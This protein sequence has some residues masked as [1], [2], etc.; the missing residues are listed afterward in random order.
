VPNWY[1][2]KTIIKLLIAIALI[3]AAA[4][5]G[6]VVAKYYQLKDETLQLLTFG[7]NTT[8]NELQNRIIEKAQT[9][10]VPVDPADIIVTRDGFH[11][12]ATVSYAQSVEVVPSYTYPIK[13]HFTSEAISMSGLGPNN[14]GA[15]V[16]K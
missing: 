14:S 8:P 13:F 5:V 15:A 4:R 9:L 12:Y 1:V 10:S 11:T 7:G 6:M 16:V 2:V 3:N